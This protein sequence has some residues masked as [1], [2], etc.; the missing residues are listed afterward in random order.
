MKPEFI[1]IGAQKAGTTWLY[2]R[3]N[4]HPEFSMPPKKEIHYFDR[5]P[6]CPSPNDLAV[7]KAS[8]RLK[9]PE[10]ALRACGKVLQSLVT[11]NLRE[12]RWWSRYYFKDY[13]DAWYRSLFELES[14]ITG[15]I[16][17]SYSILEDADIA[18]LHAV[19]PEAKLIFLLRN[20]IER[21]WS[22]YRFRE[23]FGG[24]IDLDNLD[25]FKTFVESH[26]QTARSDYLRTIDRYL[27]YHDSDQMLLGFYDALSEQ[28]EAL[29]SALL[30]H[31]GAKNTE[32][33]QGLE[34]FEN[35]SRQ[36]EMP[37]AYRDYLESRY[38]DEMEQL[39]E[40]Y[41]GYAARWL[42]PAPA[43]DALQPGL[44]PAVVRP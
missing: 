19:A 7:T 5:S 39:A 3:L 36:I 38:R 40:R 10:Y 2:A 32:H 21:A 12:A 34:Q 9:D 29:L 42:C 17:P 31:L 28:P 6:N 16:T 35:K 43:A 8:K 1:C 26:S 44:P 15:D 4:S 20:P 33:R 30:T 14:G 37:Q 27:R 24:A 11:G 41:G 23:K 13:S 22:M 18:R 25:E